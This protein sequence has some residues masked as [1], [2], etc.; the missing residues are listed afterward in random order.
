MTP[1]TQPDPSTPTCDNPEHRKGNHV[2]TNPDGSP[3]DPDSYHAGYQAG[4]ADALAGGRSV[5]ATTSPGSSPSR[6]ENERREGDGIS[7]TQPAK[8]VVARASDAAE[9]TSRTA[10][11]EMLAADPVSKRSKTRTVPCPT[12]GAPTGAPCRASQGGRPL[13]WHHHYRIKDA[14]HGEVSE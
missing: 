1:T 11:D 5:P 10:A 4:H 9:P 6:S 13:S 8:P 12:C 3:V 14:R 7:E 2:T